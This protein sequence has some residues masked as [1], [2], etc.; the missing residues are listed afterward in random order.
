VPPRILPILDRLRQDHSALLAPV[1]IEDACRLEGYTWRKRL[2]DPVVTI[3][4]FLLQI[5]HGNTACQQV[6]Q[7]GCRTFSDSAYFYSRRNL[8]PR[9]LARQVLACDFRAVS[10]RRTW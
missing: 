7:F 3:Y 1:A 10:F 6:V 5:L 8:T 2:L 4:L 9:C